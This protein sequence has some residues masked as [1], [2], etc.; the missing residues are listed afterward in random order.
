M[1]DAALRVMGKFILG[2]SAGTPGDVMFQG[3]PTD[4]AVMGRTEHDGVVVLV[5]P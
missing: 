1:V 5:C 3:P 4:R 2:Q